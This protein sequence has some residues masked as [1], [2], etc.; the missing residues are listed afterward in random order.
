MQEFNKTFIS[1]NFFWFSYFG[2]PI[3][4]SAPTQLSNYFVGPWEGAVPEGVW[5]SPSGANGKIGVEFWSVCLDWVTSQVG[6]TLADGSW[7]GDP[8]RGGQQDLG[9]DG[10]CWRRVVRGV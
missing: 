1:F 8:F 2:G 10:I 9:R 6:L 7:A 5:G 4:P 3:S